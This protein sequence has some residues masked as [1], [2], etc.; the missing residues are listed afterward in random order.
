[1]PH[2]T[3]SS[4]RTQDLSMSVSPSTTTESNHHHSWW[5]RHVTAA[6]QGQPQGGL[7]IPDAMLKLSATIRR[8]S[9]CGI[10]GCDRFMRKETCTAGGELLM[11]SEG[12]VKD[13]CASRDVSDGDD[14]IG[15][16]GMKV[17]M[18]ALRLELV[19]TVSMLKKPATTT[20]ATEIIRNRNGRDKVTFTRTLRWPT[21][22]NDPRKE[23]EDSHTSQGA[24]TTTKV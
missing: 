9:I 16:D 4:A 5:R 14:G 11:C 3:C 21:S 15:H 2:E 22:D 18:R 8:S 17:M 23:N 24:A 20:S 19:V 12:N 1:M 7:V 10:S 6:A 13:P